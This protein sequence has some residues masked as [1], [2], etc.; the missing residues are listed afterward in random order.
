MTF[1]CN[2]LLFFNFIFLQ[3]QSG[4]VKDSFLSQEVLFVNDGPA[5]D[6]K[7]LFIILSTFLCKYFCPIVASHNC[8]VSIFV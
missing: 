5:Q 6:T 1:T 2:I 7:Y 8:V 3:L 4:S